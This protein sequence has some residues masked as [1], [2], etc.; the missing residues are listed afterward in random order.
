MYQCKGKGRG[1]CS[2]RQAAG[3]AA[4]LLIGG[5]DRGGFKPAVGRPGE[6]GQHTQQR[7][8]FSGLWR[9]RLPDPPLHTLSL[10]CSYVGII[11][12]VAKQGTDD[13]GVNKL[14]PVLLS[15]KMTDQTYYSFS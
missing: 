13:T 7:L 2:I 8:H 10:H 6:T 12:F 15:S 11:G 5:S 14:H 4:L 9:G 1:S 3:G